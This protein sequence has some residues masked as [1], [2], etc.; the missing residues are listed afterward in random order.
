MDNIYITP[1]H[2]QLREQ[3]ARF[4]AR[5]VEPHALAWE[6]AG[7]TPRDLPAIGNDDG[8]DHPRY[9]LKMP[10]AVGWMGALRLMLMERPSTSRVCAG[11]ITPSSHSRAVA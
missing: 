9:I 8:P 5:E 10:N 3:I 7:F 11:S 6:E 2:E 4:I 1:E